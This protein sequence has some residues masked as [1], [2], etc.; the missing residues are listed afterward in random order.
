M[1]LSPEWAALL[2]SSGYQAVHWSEIGPGNADG[3]G[4]VIRAEQDG[5]VIPTRD[6]DFGAYLVLA[7][8]TRPR[9]IQVRAKRTFPGRYA[10]LVLDA[11][12]QTAP[13][14]DRGALV[15]VEFDRVRVR[16][17]AYPSSC[18]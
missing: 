7:G 8:R 4:I 9:V 3:E 12:R 13:A 2:M 5:A 6:L 10:Q 11:R 14:L 1:N 18:E 17:L 15:T 16:L